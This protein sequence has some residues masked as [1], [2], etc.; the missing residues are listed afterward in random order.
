MSPSKM[1]L[2]FGLVAVSAILAG[3]A[4]GFLFKAL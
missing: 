1:G 3:I 4:T 2:I